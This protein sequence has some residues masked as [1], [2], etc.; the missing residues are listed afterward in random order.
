MRPDFNLGDIVHSMHIVDIDMFGTYKKILLINFCMVDDD[1]FFFGEVER[2]LK[3]F[4]FGD[5]RVLRF[6]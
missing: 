1:M 6:G 5:G 3:F 4:I 2:I